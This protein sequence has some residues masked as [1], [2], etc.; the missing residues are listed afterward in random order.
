[1]RCSHDCGVLG[2]IVA[3]LALGLFLVAGCSSDSPTTPPATRV[4]E[5]GSL[6]SVYS[7]DDGDLALYE[8]EG[9]KFWGD[10]LLSQYRTAKVVVSQQSGE[11]EVLIEVRNYRVSPPSL[12]PDNRDD[13]FELRT[14]TVGAGPACLQGYAYGFSSEEGSVVLEDSEGWEAILD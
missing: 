1:M 14:C 4:S 9:V 7:F 8:Y 5:M 10:I 13:W 12:V 11:G 3:V 6:I 2:S